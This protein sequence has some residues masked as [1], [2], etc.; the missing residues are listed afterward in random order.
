M[1]CLHCRVR[2]CCNAEDPTHS[3]ELE[4]ILPENILQAVAYVDTFYVDSAATPADS[5]KQ[6]TW[7]LSPCLRSP[8]NDASGSGETPLPD[9]VPNTMEAEPSFVP[10]MDVRP[11]RRAPIP[12]HTTSEPPPPAEVPS[13]GGAAPITEAPLPRRVR[14]ATFAICFFF[15]SIVRSSHLGGQRNAQRHPWR[16]EPL[17]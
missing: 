14:Y 11:A 8:S 13:S 16:S 12:T 1:Y 7:L 5:Q 2:T 3:L 9:I 10:P 15:N 4:F 6:S 17:P